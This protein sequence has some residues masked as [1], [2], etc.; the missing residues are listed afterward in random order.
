MNDLE[1]ID[2][3][4]AQLDEIRTAITGG[5]Y[6]SLQGLLLSQTV[7]LHKLGVEFIAKSKEQAVIKHKAAYVDIALR[8]L[9]QSQKAM[10]AIKLLRVEKGKI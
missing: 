2:S 4:T 10:R 5:D 6:S 1:S 9:G 3:A 7:I 8:A